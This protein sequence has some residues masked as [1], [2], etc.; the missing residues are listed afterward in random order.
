MNQNSAS[1]SISPW[2]SEDWNRIVL[3]VVMAISIWAFLALT[4]HRYLIYPDSMEYAQ[5]ARNLSQGKGAVTDTIWVLR[6]AYPFTRPPSDVRRPLLWSAVVSVFFRFFGAEDWVVTLASGIIGCCSVVLLYLLARRCL[7]G[8]ESFL[9]ALIY[10][11]QREVIILNQSG[12]SEPLFTALLLLVCLFWLRSKTPWQSILLGI[13]VG[14]TQ[15]VRLNGFLILIPLV[16]F[17]LLLRQERW[18]LKTL[19]LLIGFILAVLPIAIRNQMH[20]GEFTILNLQR[21]IVVGDIPPYPAHG[22][23]RALEKIS[24]IRVFLAEPRAVAVKYVSGLSRNLN[25]LLS[26]ANPL[27]WGLFLIP[28]FS[29]HSSSEIK[30]LTWFALLLLIILWL[31]FSIGEFEGSRFYVPVVSLVTLGAIGGLKILL[32]QNGGGDSLNRKEW[33]KNWKALVLILFLVLP[34]LFYL[35]EAA[36]HPPSQQAR[37]ALGNL[38]EYAV[39]QDAVVASDVPWATGWYGKRLSIWLPLMPVE[40]DTVN[41]RLAVDYII[42]TPGVHADDWRDTIW[43]QIYQGLFSIPGYELLF[44]RSETGIYLVF[45]KKDSLQSTQAMDESNLTGNSLQDNLIP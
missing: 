13:L 22:A 23:E 38:I 45:K 5:T 9:V 16:L 36:Q 37:Y 15:W 25:S 40:M 12:L 3:L 19:F 39:P 30:R 31:N 20:L 7:E 29:R 6:T 4:G 43:P 28:L 8:L 17:E 26:A 18:R 10:L 14:L 32:G 2:L 11:L 41:E 42:L 27:L 21:Y 44:P 35:G 24:V 33:K 34:G 1:Q